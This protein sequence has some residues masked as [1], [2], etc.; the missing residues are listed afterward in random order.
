MF[1]IAK[2]I[3]SLMRRKG[4]VV[5]RQSKHQIWRDARGNQIVTPVSPSDQRVIKHVESQIKKIEG[6]K[7]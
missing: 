4:F 6:D 2:S 3:S 7:R 1:G 5:V